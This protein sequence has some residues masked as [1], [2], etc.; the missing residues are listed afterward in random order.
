MHS[1][2]AGRFCGKEIWSGTCLC[3]SP[4]DR[5]S[6]DGNGCD[7]ILAERARRGSVAA[8]S[9][10]VARY[11]E[12]VYVIVQNMF[13]SPLDAAEVTHQVFLRLH[14]A[15][16]SWP[17]SPAFATSLYRIA[18]KT[19]LG[20][21]LEDRRSRPCSL[22]SFLPRFDRDGRLV[23]GRWLDLGTSTLEQIEV[24]AVL[25][26]AFEYMDD[27]VR[28][29]FILRD[30]LELPTDEVAA[31]LETSS[32]DICRRV[33]RARLMLRGILDRLV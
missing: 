2:A 3:S 24:G 20:R 15:L 16:P 4:M 10:L 23:P 26:E 29:A 28:A 27:A 32:K 17:G 19:A 5:T 6:V 13:A 7:D 11:R 12:P 18:M 25:R 8:F 14:D 30:V 21:R 31:V 1:S 22:E 33:H 9:A